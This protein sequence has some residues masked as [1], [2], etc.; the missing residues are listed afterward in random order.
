LVDDFTIFGFA[1]FNDF[2]D[3]QIMFGID[4]GQNPRLWI[5]SVNTAGFMTIGRNDGGASDVATFHAGEWFHFIFTWNAGEERIEVFI[6]GIK[7]T[8]EINTTFTGVGA[9]NVMIGGSHTATT[10]EFHGRFSRVG[11]L[12]DVLGDRQATLLFLRASTSVKR[13]L[14]RPT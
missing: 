5:G 12:K 1:K 3:N 11:I 14:F 7:H 2:L 8:N 13:H 4:P 9:G 6:N 10:R